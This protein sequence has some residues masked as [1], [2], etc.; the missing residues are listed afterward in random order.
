MSHQEQ[1]YQW[2]RT[3]VRH[4]PNLSKSQ[5]SVLALWTF[6]MVLARACSLSAVTGIIAALMQRKDNTVRQQLREF[7]REAKAKVGQKRKEIEVESCFCPL[8]A[9]VLS[10]WPAK[11]IALA[12]DASNLAD[13][14]TV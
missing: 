11:Q 7:Y 6:G 1:L 3:I 5:A 8:L 10:W 14:F 9:W 4:L 12:I 13:R 2:N